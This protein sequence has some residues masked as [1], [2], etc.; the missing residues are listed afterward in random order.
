M[1]RKTS[2]PDDPRLL[3]W[4]AFAITGAFLLSFYLGFMRFLA[5]S[6]REFAA[7]SLAAM[8]YL[9]GQLLLARLVHPRTATQ[10]RSV[11]ALCPLIGGAA[12][13][14]YL[15]LSAATGFGPIVHGLVWGTVHGAL[16][17][18]R[19]GRAAAGSSAPAP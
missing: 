1:D 12:G 8:G 6:W 9:A 19:A 18:R 15:A 14:A 5:G 13:G 3:G 10:W 4:I 17:A 11:A 2:S 7:L 16:I